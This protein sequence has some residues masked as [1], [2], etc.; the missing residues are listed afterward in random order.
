MPMRVGAAL[1]GL[2]NSMNDNGIRPEMIAI[3]GGL[4]GLIG[5]PLFVLGDILSPHAIRLVG[6]GLLTGT[7]FCLAIAAGKR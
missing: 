2:R 5:M 1:N 3:A 7:V 6:I 4:L